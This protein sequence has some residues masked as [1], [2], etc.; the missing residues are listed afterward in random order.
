MTDWKKESRSLSAIITV[1]LISFYLPVGNDRFNNAVMESLH[2]VKWYAQEHVLL[3]LVPAFFIAGAI[4]VFISQ[5]AVMKYLGARANKVLSYSVASVSG[6]ILAVCSCTVLPLFGGIYQRGAGLGPATSFLYSG[7]AINILAIILTARVLGVE[8]GI[9]RAVGAILFSVVIGILMHVIFRRE[10]L[11]KAADQAQI[12]E[13]DAKRPLWQNA[14]CLGAMIAILVFVNW[15]RPQQSVGLWYG[16]YTAKWILT[17]A[18]AI[19]LSVILQ[20]SGRH[21][22]RCDKWDDWANGC[23]YRRITLTCV[24]NMND[25]HSTN[26]V[27]LFVRCPEF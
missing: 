18:A 10:E 27:V 6:V 24:V 9:A 3:C 12:P 19:T 11:K 14:L 25:N 5:S 1:F 2:L 16:I 8:L 20:N 15:G 7:P 22:Q 4:A 17:G 21:A 23:H 26:L 13:P